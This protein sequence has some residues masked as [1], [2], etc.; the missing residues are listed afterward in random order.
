MPRFKIGQ[1]VYVPEKDEAVEATIWA[2]EAG[3]FEKNGNLG[4]VISGYRIRNFVSVRRGCDS[5]L[6]S[7]I[8]ERDFYDD[9]KKAQEASKF[10]EVTLDEEAWRIAVGDRKVKDEKSPYNLENCNLP[11]CCANIS[12]ARD[13]LLY[14]KRNGGLI[15]HDREELRR[16]IFHGHDLRYD[17]QSPIAQIFKQLQIG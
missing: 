7:V 6:T 9:Q 1:T 3:I 4:G 12:E 2:Y 10:L 16:N 8:R 15:V 11:P 13:I 14:C 5:D 17:A